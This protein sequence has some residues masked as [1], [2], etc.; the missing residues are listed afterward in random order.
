MS[1]MF[2]SKI[3]HLLFFYYISF[4]VCE[5]NIIHKEKKNFSI[6]HQRGKTLK[7]W[8]FKRKSLSE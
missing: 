7:I 4:Q 6:L 5:K 2:Y 1:P 8:K 3:S